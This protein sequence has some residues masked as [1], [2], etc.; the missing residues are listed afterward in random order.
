M[1][2]CECKCKCKQQCK[3]EK[4]NNTVPLL[5][6]EEWMPLG[7]TGNFILLVMAAVC[8]ITGFCLHFLKS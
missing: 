3:K 8:L 7:E 6:G 2:E 4:R 5:G 1:C